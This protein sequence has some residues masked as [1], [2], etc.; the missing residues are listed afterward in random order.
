MAAAR[1]SQGSRPAVRR[2][3]CLAVVERWRLSVAHRKANLAHAA[4]TSAFAMGAPSGLALAPRLRVEAW[5]SLASRLQRPHHPAPPCCRGH[6]WAGIAAPLAWAQDY[7]SRLNR[8][9]H[10]AAARRLAE[11]RVSACDVPAV[12]EY[13]AAAQGVV[14]GQPSLACPCGLDGPLHHAGHTPTPL[15]CI[16][17]H[18]HRLKRG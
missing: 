8:G 18:A 15:L 2:W 13:Q 5:M 7:R 9:T 6:G 11:T 1:W 17:R 14:R 12:H 16:M 10:C 3:R 4:T